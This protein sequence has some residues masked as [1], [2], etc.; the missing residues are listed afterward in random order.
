MGRYKMGKIWHFKF[1]LI[2]LFLVLLN[3]NIWSQEKWGKISKEILNLSTFTKDTIADAVTL[4]DVGYMEINFDDRGF[5]LE[6]KRHTRIKIFREEGKETANIKIPYYHED[7]IRNLKAQTILP[8]GKK[9][10]LKSDNIFEETLNKYWKQKVFSIPGVEIGSVFEYE[11]KLQSKYL[12][13]LEPWY[14]QNPTFTL[15][16][17]YTVKLYPGFHYNAITQQIYGIEPEVEEFIIPGLVVRKSKIF[18]WT[19]EDIPPLKEE[20]FTRSIKDYRKSL[21]FQLVEF[22]NPFIHHRFIQSWEDLAKEIRETFKEKVTQ[23]SGLKDYVKTVVTDSM[24]ELIKTETVSNLI[25]NEIETDWI[26]TAYPQK[27]PIEVLNNKKGIM[28]DKNLL[29][30]NLLRNINIDANPVLISTRSHGQLDKNIP[31]LQQFNHVLVCVKIDQG[32]NFYDTSERYCPI[33]FLPDFTNVG[34]GLLITDNNYKFV[35]IPQSKSLNSISCNTDLILNTEG[36]IFCKTILR[37]EGYTAVSKREQISS[38]NNQQEYFSEWITKKYAQA[39][40]DSFRI[41]NLESL[42]GPLYIYLS[43]KV[44]D[45]AQ[46]TGRNI[47]FSPPLMTKV[48]KNPYKSEKRI[49]PVDYNYCRGWN[50]KVKTILPQGYSVEEIPKQLLIKIPDFSYMTKY[51]NEKNVVTFIKQFLIKKTIFQQKEYESLRNAYTN[52]VNSEGD[53]IVFTKAEMSID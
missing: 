33:K 44:P 2:L 36:H 10:K 27:E 20:P 30:I 12:A 1:I 48:G 7:K 23:N 18:T 21:T 31:N 24:S 22:K 47:Y 50:E 43:Y 45:Y 11:Y 26:Y 46:V 34:E 49:Y 25:K 13:F 32:Y 8:N 14:F 37:Y 17:K 52:I 53:Q 16:S 35:K 5:F 38:K 28:T 4:F 39:A 41:E 15:L 9:I 6:I 3:K 51:I 29:L 19:L 42:E 40:L